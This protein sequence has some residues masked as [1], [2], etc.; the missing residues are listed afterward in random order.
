MIEW[1][2]SFEAA[3]VEAERERRMVLIDFSKEH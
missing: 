2:Q 3:R 1:A